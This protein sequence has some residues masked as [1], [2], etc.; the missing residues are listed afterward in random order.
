MPC[1]KKV[2]YTK[3]SDWVI[4]AKIIYF[5]IAHFVKIVGYG[6]ILLRKVILLME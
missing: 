6:K 4:I 2:I 3:I 5:Q 1:S